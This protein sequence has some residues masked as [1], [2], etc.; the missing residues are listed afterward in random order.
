MIY[1]FTANLLIRQLG[2][3]L[4]AIV[5]L[6]FTNLCVRNTWLGYQLLVEKMEL[7]I[8]CYSNCIYLT[9]IFFLLLSLWLSCMLWISLS[10]IP[11]ICPKM[12]LLYWYNLCLLFF[13]DVKVV[14]R[15]IQGKHCQS[16]Q[17]VSTPANPS[18]YIWLVMLAE[19]LISVQDSLSFSRQ[20]VRW[21]HH[22]RVNSN[23]M[24]NLDRRA[25]GKL[26]VSI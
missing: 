2:F 22:L 1:T 26:V 13:H 20:V 3:C 10:H 16:L 18:Y 21:S 8:K 11:K 9:C 25:Q 24:I 17:P 12:G 19:T 5:S 7:L 23:M 15:W 14:R 4:I 6:L